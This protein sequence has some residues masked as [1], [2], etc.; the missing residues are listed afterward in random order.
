MTASSKKGSGAVSLRFSSSR[1]LFLARKEETR[2]RNPLLDENHAAAAV[3]IDD[4]RRH[5]GKEWERR[6]AQERHCIPSQRSRSGLSPV[7]YLSFC[8]SLVPL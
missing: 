7:L 6:R 2:L 5:A 8:L 3:A 1:S 4:R